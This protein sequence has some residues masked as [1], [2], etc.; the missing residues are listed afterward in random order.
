MVVSSTIPGKVYK[1]VHR[2]DEFILTNIKNRYFENEWFCIQEDGKIILKGTTQNGYAWDGCSPKWEWI[3][4][5][6]GTPDGRFDKNTTL[7]ITYFSSMF[8]D[9]FYQF[10][11]EI[12]LSRK[13]TDLIFKYM[14]NRAGFKLAGIYYLFVRLFG[15]L[16]GKWL[17]TQTEKKLHISGQSW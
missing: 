12:P 3:D 4:I 7:P 11:A 9:V 5:T 14:L 15:G 6:W 13:E 2:K 8:H 1:F 16:F 10:K 17:T